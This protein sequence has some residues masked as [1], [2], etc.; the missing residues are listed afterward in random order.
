MSRL[1]SLLGVVSIAFLA[2]A[3]NPGQNFDPERVF[4]KGDTNGDKKM[5]LTEFVALTKNLP[6]FKDN[7]AFGKIVFNRLD[8]N[9][10]G[11]LTLDNSKKSPT[12]GNKT[13]RP[14]SPN[15]LPRINP[16]PR[17]NSRSS[18]KKFD[19]SSSTIAT[20]AIRK[21]RAKPR[22]VCWSIVGKGYVKAAKLG[23]QWYPEV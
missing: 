18:R 22:A 6:R 4:Q 2:F 20:S 16:Q 13:T 15:Q 1:L 21:S 10:D 8:T 14:Q 19:R 23:R 3:Q 9:K 11:S 7:P 12:S 5:S 17:I